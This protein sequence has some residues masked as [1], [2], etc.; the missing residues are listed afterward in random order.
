MAKQTRADQTPVPHNDVEKLPERPRRPGLVQ[1]SLYLPIPMHS[2]LRETAFKE[3]RSIHSIVLEG[4]GLALN[5]RE[6]KK[7]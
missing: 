1:T 3:R 2:A 4:I 7:R 5:N 6:R